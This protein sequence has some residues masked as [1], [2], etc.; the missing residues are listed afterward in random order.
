MIKNIAV[1]KDSY[2]GVHWAQLPK[3][4]DYSY[5]YGEPRKGGRY[6]FISF[7]GLQMIIQDHL[8]RI[9]NEKDINYGQ[10]RSLSTFG[11][12][13]Y[14]NREVWERVY[15]L[16]YL[17]MR[18]KS[19]PEG[20]KIAEGN[21]CFTMESTEL[22]FA[23]T[24]NSLETVLMNVWYPTAV[25]TRAMYLKE[26]IRPFFD[27]SS[28]IADLIM[29]VAVNDF[30]MRGATCHEAAAR[31]GAGFLL[32]FMGSDNEAAQSA[33]DY[34]YNDNSSRLKSVWATEH[35]VALAY[36]LTD[37]NEKE[38]L[39]AQLQRAD[40]ELIISV[41]IDTR[42]SDNF[43][44]NIVGDPEIKNLIKARKGRV[45]L[46]PDSGDPLT[47][48]LKYLDILGGL[49]GYGINNKGYKVVN[50]NVGLIQGDGMT[51]TSIPQLYRDVVNAG[52][53]ADNFVTGSGGGLLQEGLTR[54]TSR[55][56]IKPSY[57]ERNGV[58]Y[59]V[60]KDPKT[61][62]SK[63][64]KCG[65]LKLHTYSS[66]YESSKE[67]PQQFAAYADQMRVVLDNGNFYPE[68]FKTILERANG[69]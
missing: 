36:G 41:V 32:H 16:G 68:D 62:P 21:V 12:P 10:K 54:D 15:K 56:A 23:K 60:A 51:E 3:D 31:G 38:Y 2:K 67:T 66:T 63:R 49:F 61:D 45:V 29:P 11:T 64:S 40:P 7:F 33:L 28:D 57:I 13:M 19:A 50:D 39:M 4:L 9:P 18:I 20:A 8:L 69:K 58:G 47:N 52:W 44:Q 14:F 37:L 43:M 46:R 48:V 42:D 17:P 53:A 25:A 55:W 24:V 34:Y 59:N 5:S 22:W 1:D 65:K 35:Q 6:P 30:G 26:N 27:K